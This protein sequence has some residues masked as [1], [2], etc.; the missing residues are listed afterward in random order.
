MERTTITVPT[1]LID[2]T[3]TPVMG[4][5]FVSDDMGTLSITLTLQEGRWIGNP[6]HFNWRPVQEGQL[7]DERQAHYY[8]TMFSY[9]AMREHIVEEIRKAGEADAYL[10]LI[11]MLYDNVNDFIAEVRKHVI[12]KWPQLLNDSA[13]RFALQVA[14]ADLVRELETLKENKELATLW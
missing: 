12:Q 9:P 7:F 1:L 4:K 10:T 13:D 3:S 2:V 14:N 6:R 5:V 8:H 11:R